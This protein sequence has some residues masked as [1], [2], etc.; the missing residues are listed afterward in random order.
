MCTGFGEGTGDNAGGVWDIKP[1]GKDW[2]AQ[3]IAVAAAISLGV[4]DALYRHAQQAMWV[5]TVPFGSYYRSLLI[6]LASGDEQL[7][8]ANEDCEFNARIHQ[9]GGKVWLDP[10]IRSTY[11]APA[12]SV[13]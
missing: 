12:T 5:D 10:A 7:L 13:S 6:E 3:G 8:A 2:Q 1:S 4:G 9:S 11:Y